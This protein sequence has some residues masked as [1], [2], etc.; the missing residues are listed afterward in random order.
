MLLR[1]SKSLSPAGRA[2]VIT[3]ASSG[4]GKYCALHL[5]RLGFHVFAGVRKEADGERLVTESSA[6]RPP[7]RPLRID[8][9]DDGS[10]RAAAETVAEIRGTDGLWAV[11]NNAGTCVSAPLECVRPERL[12]QEL[13]TNVV[14]PHAVSQ[15]FL[16]M[17]RETRG[18]VVNVT[19]GLGSVASPYLGTYAAGQFAKEGLTDALRREVAPFGIA[20]SLIQPGA[21]ATPIWGKVGELGEQLVRTSP[22]GVAHLYRQSFERFLE[23][24]QRRAETSR[25]QPRDV[26]LAVTHA[27]TAVRPRIRYRVG[28]DAWTAAVASRLL[29]DAVVDRLLAASLASGKVPGAGRV[30]A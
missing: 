21:I 28:P 6:G 13:D 17:L 20:V 12:R 15:A 26:A 1:Q 22:D 9:T 30:D 8:V 18:R 2:V 19:S 11:V 7:I 4:L 25:T 10:I 24:N 23:M 3:G 29:P 14:G 16:P 27:L 5:Q